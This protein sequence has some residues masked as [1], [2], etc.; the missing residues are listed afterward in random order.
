[1]TPISKKKNT[2]GEF[3]KINNIGEKQRVKGV[4]DK[5]SQEI[6]PDTFSKLKIFLQ[7]ISQGQ[8]RCMESQNHYP[9]C[10]HQ[11]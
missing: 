3:L 8:C 1:M 10:K 7:N 11:W 2:C 6:I 4:K 5:T 9:I